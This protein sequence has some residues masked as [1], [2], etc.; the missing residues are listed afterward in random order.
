MYAWLSWLRK[1]FS[2][3]IASFSPSQLKY[4][5]GID[6]TIQ[7]FRCK[8]R[9]G[10]S[11]FARRQD[12][13]G[14]KVLSEDIATGLK[15]LLRCE[16]F[17]IDDGMN[18]CTINPCNS[19]DTCSVISK[20]KWWEIGAV[21]SWQLSTT[22]WKPI[23]VNACGSWQPTGKLTGFATDWWTATISATKWPALIVQ[24][25]RFI[26]ELELLVSMWRNAA[27]EYPTV[28]T[29]ATREAAVSCLFTLFLPLSLELFSV[30]R[31]CHYLFLIL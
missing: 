30:F 21:L 3:L 27:T 31:T 8:A 16:L 7:Q 18:S 6:L 1:Y 2:N 17:P 24:R 10:L 5:I 15:D 22:S 4:T 29:A 28:P 20:H 25:V 11:Q 9:L 13:V 12:F 26:A 14:N 23:R 19:Y